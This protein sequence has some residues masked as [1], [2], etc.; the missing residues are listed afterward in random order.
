MMTM[1]EKLQTL[2]KAV[3]VNGAKSVSFFDGQQYL[4]L[5]DYLSSFSNSLLF[6]P[7]YRAE[8]FDYIVKELG[9]NL[10][11]ELAMEV[12][13]YT[14]NISTTVRTISKGFVY[15]KTTTMCGRDNFFELLRQ[16][17]LDLLVEVLTA[18]ANTADTVQS[19][20][21]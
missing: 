13:V 11:Y 21:P 2:A 9:C 18:S 20:N 12:G 15:F 4:L 19:T 5:K 8:D 10:S 6:N 17:T 1:E 7:Y 16:N 14:V 3:G